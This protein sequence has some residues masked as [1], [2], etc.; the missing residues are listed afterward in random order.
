MTPRNRNKVFILRE[1]SGAYGGAIVLYR[2]EDGSVNLDVRLDKDTIW[3]SQK[4][5]AD[6]FATE[7]SV[8]TKHLRNIF[9]TG[10]LDEKSNVQKNALSSLR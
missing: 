9:Q 6:L 7:R 2:A 4:Q 8:I 5:M 10:E 3:L 1:E